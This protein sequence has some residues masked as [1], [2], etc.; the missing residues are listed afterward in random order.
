MPVD[1]ILTSVVTDRK[2]HMLFNWSCVEVMTIVTST[3]L[4]VFRHTLTYNNMYEI[5]H[6]IVYIYSKLSHG[7]CLYTSVLAKGNG[8]EHFSNT[9][10]TK[11]YIL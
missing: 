2:H 9:F 1:E 8:S 4:H 10:A 5:Y 3:M 7:L 11:A 6:S